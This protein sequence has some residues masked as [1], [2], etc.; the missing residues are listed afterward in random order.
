MQNGTMLEEAE[1]K[2]FGDRLFIV[3]RVP[4]IGDEEWDCNIESAVAGTAQCY[5]VFESKEEYI[6]RL[7]KVKPSTRGF[8]A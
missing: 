3:G 8:D 4:D 6:N 1:F 5:L 7:R 2:T